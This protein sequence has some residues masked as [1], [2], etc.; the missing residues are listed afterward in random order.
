MYVLTLEILK[1]KSWAQ[2][3]LQPHKRWSRCTMEK[4]GEGFFQEIKREDKIS[5]LIVALIISS[6]N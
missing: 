3:Y 6:A 1:Y 2:R 4:V 5:L